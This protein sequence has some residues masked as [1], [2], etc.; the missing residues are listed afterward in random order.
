MACKLRVANARKKVAHWISGHTGVG[1]PTRFGYARQ[2]SAIR[3]FPETDAAE[4]EVSHESAFSSTAPTAAYDTRG[5]LGC[6][7]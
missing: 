4:V 1:L 6:P 2:F 3:E 5:K 7:Q